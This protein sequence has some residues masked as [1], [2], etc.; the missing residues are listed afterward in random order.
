MLRT[1]ILCLFAMTSVAACGRGAEAP[2]AES[3]RLTLTPSD[4]VEA[5]T[6]SLTDGV[7]ISGPLEPTQTVPL[8]AQINAIVRS[9][10]VDRGSRVRRGDTLVVLEANGLHGVAASAKAAV[11]AAEA[12]LALATQRLDAAR[13]MHASGG[14]SDYDLKSSEASRQMAEAQASAARAQLATASESESRAT[15]V[16]PI[17]GIVS[18]RVAEPG[19]AVRDG[20]VMITVVDTRTLEL[21]ARVGVDDAMRVRPGAPV[22]F[23]LDAVK[24]Q[25][26]HG[27]VARIDPRA[28]PATRQVGI[29]SELPNR[30]G[31]IVAGQFAHG[32]VLTGT[33]SLMV[34]IPASAVMDSAGHARVF[35][36]KDGRLS[37][38]SIVLGPRDDVLGLV[39][40]RSGLAPGDRILATPVIGAAEGLAVAMAGDTTAGR[41]MPGA[42]QPPAKRP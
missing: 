31:R 7:A 40:V 26:F 25:T 23:T 5:R 21:H 15:I 2:A 29:A 42:S 8:R 35:I 33:P 37:T 16:S 17:D 30:D 34:A 39:G 41:A 13:R 36:V 9:I 1:R 14:I 19:E 11:A 12:N 6:V 18:D 10:R 20:N 3:T 27:R 32:R 28:D 22:M 4:I 24:G 38:R